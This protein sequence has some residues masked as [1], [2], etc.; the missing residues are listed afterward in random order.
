MATC[1]QCRHWHQ[2]QG[3]LGECRARPPVP[4]LSQAIHSLGTS[5]EVD[6]AWPTLHRDDFCGE[7][8]P[9]LV[10]RAALR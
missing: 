6:R 4:V 3:P 9:R 10:P 2:R 5:H 8:A 7:H 1:G